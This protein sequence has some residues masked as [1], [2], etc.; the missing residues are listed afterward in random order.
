MVLLLGLLTYL[1][2]LTSEN[3]KADYQSG[4][5]KIT[6]PKSEENKGKKIKI[7]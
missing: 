6:I 1:A 3:I 2:L 4:V 7:S 5:L